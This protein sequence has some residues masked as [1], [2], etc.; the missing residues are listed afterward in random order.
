MSDTVKT[1][2]KGRVIDLN[3][4]KVTL[5]NNKECELE[6]IQHPGGVAILAV[7]ETGR[8]CLLR[9]YRFAAG[10]WIWELPAGRLEPGESPQVCAQ[11]ELV[12]EAGR[13]AASWQRLGEVYSS[14]GVFTEVI[15]LYLARD[16]KTVDDA[17]EEHEV[18]EVHW[19]PL[20]KIEAMI[21]AGE[22]NDA[23]TICAMYYFRDLDD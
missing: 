20:P 15:H 18:F 16:L 4:N 9:Q 8:I 6:I 11:R 10:G 2:Y 12:E 7:G 1:I 19:L 22:I 23:K 3:L 13:N 17:P 5:P 21:K 14:P